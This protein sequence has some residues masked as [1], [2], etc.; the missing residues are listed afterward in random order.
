[1]LTKHGSF[2]IAELI[3]GEGRTIEFGPNT[4]VTKPSPYLFF[5]SSY[6]SSN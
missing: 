6:K 3:K 2:A 5:S 4:V 1:M